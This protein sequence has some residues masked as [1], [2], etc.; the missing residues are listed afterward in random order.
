ME[1]SVRER[2]CWLRPARER[3]GAI[4]QECSGALRSGGVS[5]AKDRNGIGSDGNGRQARERI[6][7]LRSELVWSGKAGM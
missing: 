3:N 7:G 5:R 1:R 6:A 2:C 4:G